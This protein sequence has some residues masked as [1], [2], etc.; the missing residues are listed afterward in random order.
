GLIDVALALG[1]A[2]CVGAGVSR[3]GEYHVDGVVGGG[4][5]LDLGSGEATVWEEQ[6]LLQEPEPGLA[7]RTKLQKTLEDAADGV[8]DRLIGVQ[9]YLALV[10]SPDQ[11]DRQAPAQLTPLSLV[12]DAAIQTCPQDVQLS[13]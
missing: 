10:L 11:T 12:P 7:R 5:P 9:E 13:L 3:V 2:V 8:S 6:L 4:Y 1:P